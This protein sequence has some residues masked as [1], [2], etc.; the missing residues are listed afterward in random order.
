LSAICLNDGGK[1]LVR[2]T[3]VLHAVADMRVDIDSLIL[4]RGEAEIHVFLLV[5][6]YELSD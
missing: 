3:K 5:E 2:S 1:N 6:Y 4:L